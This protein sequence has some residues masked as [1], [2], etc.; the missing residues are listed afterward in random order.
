MRPRPKQLM[1]QMMAIIQDCCN[2]KVVTMVK[3]EV[4]HQEVGK[5]EDLINP[6][7]LGKVNG[8]LLKRMFL[9]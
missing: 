5:E 7:N 4:H 2:L 3:K 6:N 9:P 1:N 8:L